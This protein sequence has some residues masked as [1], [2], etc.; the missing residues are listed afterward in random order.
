MI[1]L[2][3]EQILAVINMTKVILTAKTV[4]CLLGK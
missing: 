1:A 4:Q 2:L 3:L